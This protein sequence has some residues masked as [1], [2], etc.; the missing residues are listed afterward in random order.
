MKKQ[1]LRWLLLLLPLIALAPVIN[2][3]IYP[4]D[5]AFSDLTI[6]F[7]PNALQVHN[8]V[9]QYHTLPFWSD[10]IMAGFP[11][12]ADPMSGLWYLPMWLP[13]LIPGAASFNLVII[14]HLI[15]AGFG[16]TLFLK[17]EGISDFSALVGGVVFEMTPKI[18]AHMGAG[19]YTLIMAVSWT[20]WLL[21]AQKE[22]VLSGYS[23]K[24]L[25]YPGI[26][27]GL[28]ILANPVWGPYAALIWVAYALASGIQ[29]RKNQTAAGNTRWVLKIFGGGIAQAVLALLISTPLWLPLTELTRLSSRSLMTV[30][31]RLIYSL[32]PADL[33]NLLIPNIGGMQEWVVYL[34]VFTLFLGIFSLWKN[35]K[36]PLTIFW[37]VIAGAGILISLGS[38]LPLVSAIYRLPL[39]DLLRVPTKF[40][41]LT[42]LA[43]AIL[44]AFGFESLVT[45]AEKPSPG[46]NRLWSGAAFF[47]MIIAIGIPVV[48]HLWKLQFVWTL[49]AF[50]VSLVFLFIWGKARLSSLTLGMLAIILISVDVMGI[51][52]LGLKFRPESQM[53]SEGSAIEEFL[54]TQP[55][56]YRVY[57]PSYSLPQQTA[58]QAD[59]R[60][61]EGV[62][63]LMLKSYVGFME[64]TTGILVTHYSVTMPDFPNGKPA[65]DNTGYI[66]DAH[67]LGLMNV[68]YVISQFEI[69]AKGLT[70]LKTFCTTRIYENQDWLRFAWVQPETTALGEGVQSTPSVVVKPNEFSL[71]AMGPGQ[72]VLSEVAYP[73]WKLF[74]DGKEQPIKVIDGIFIGADL[75]S[76]NQSIRI[77]YHPT[78]LLPA[79]VMAAIAWIGIVVFIILSRKK[80][81]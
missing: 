19:H 37:G 7:Y 50:G 22:F 80:R 53:L 55:G 3:F 51:N 33:L 26:V 15:L 52:L 69:S 78:F 29:D 35:K 64:K 14:F 63:P 79:L 77:E 43:V 38:N 66:P 9:F 12:V 67:L 72:L 48:T 46:F 4:R 39:F 10:L 36:Q 21:L 68:R 65:T 31:D 70:L 75:K 61:A 73:G 81:A 54:K 44:C 40:Y 62:N 34:G 59:I 20:P 25:F 17:R 45:R 76:G 24:R 60:L 49:A 47:A 71:E 28:I 30:A 6:S 74:I 23:W 2:R 11:L 57:S 18:W 1:S 8:A 56:D 32:P 58:V 27:F 41:L 13:N 42:C 5:S 16:M